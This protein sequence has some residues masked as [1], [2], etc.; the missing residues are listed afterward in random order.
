MEKAIAQK[1]RPASID[2]FT[3]EQRFFLSW[4][5]IWREKQSDAAERLQVNT[6]PHSPGKWRVNGPLSMMPEF[7]KAFGCKTGDAM[8]LPDSLRARIW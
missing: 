5:Q 6:N 7:A 1:G 4:A 2:G 3:P 8:V